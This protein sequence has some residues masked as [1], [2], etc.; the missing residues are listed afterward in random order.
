M[1][2]EISA[3]HGG[4][5]EKAKKSIKAAKE[6]GANAVKIQSYT[7]DT[8]TL[9]SSKPDFK[10]KK[11]LW[12][13]YNL[14]QLYKEAYT[15]FEWHSNLF[16]YAKELEITIFSTPFD[17]T[18]VDLLTKLNTPAFKI[19]SFEL[20]DLPLIKYVAKQNKPIFISTGMASIEE[21]NDA[22]E[23]CKLQDNKDIILFHC[24][25][26]Y[27]SKV[28][29]A[30][31]NNIKFLSKYFSIDVGLSDHTID[32]LASTL[33]ISMGACAIEKH[34]K[35]D[36][37]ENGPDSSFSLLPNQ[38]SKL[39]KTCNTSFLALG[40]REKFNRPKSEENNKIFRRSLYFIKDLKKGDVI[41]EKDIRRVR[42]GYGIEPK[43]FEE[44]IGKRLAD[45][46]EYGDPVT[47]NKLIK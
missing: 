3:N 6:A 22:I 40:S 47:W 8:M 33:A 46:V 44:I 7:P 43:Y 20:T 30:N 27:P 29:E 31:L 41:T 18:A 36:V 21:I 26:N 13:N 11:G 39:V 15:P 14:Y 23:V 4:S 32:D 34:F 19:A 1:I 10:I 2:A 38:F 9:N 35:L 25:S 16:K 5:I 37:K 42:P 45:N 17:E 24:I 28:E 12:K